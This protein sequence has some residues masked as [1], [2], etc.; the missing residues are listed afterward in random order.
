[1]RR[2]TEGFYDTALN[3][4]DGAELRK[5]LPRPWLVAKEPRCAEGHSVKTMLVDIEVRGRSPSQYARKYYVGDSVAASIKDLMTPARQTLRLFGDACSGNSCFTNPS[6]E[7]R[8][9]SKNEPVRSRGDWMI[10]P[11]QANPAV[12]VTYPPSP[13]KRNL[14]VGLGMHRLRA[15]K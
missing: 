9:G 6:T 10:Q 5:I 12:T 14:A 2:T 8:T 11:L 4:A 13:S 15:K 3:E 7:S 1:L